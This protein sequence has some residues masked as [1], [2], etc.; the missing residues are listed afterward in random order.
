V[1]SFCFTSSIFTLRKTSFWPFLKAK[2]TVVRSP[3]MSWLTAANIVF[4]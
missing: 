2:E 3:N 4:A 1:G